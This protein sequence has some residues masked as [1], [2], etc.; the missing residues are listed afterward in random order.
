M[1][2]RK[3]KPHNLHAYT[4]AIYGNKRTDLYHVHCLVRREDGTEIELD[5]CLCNFISQIFRSVM[6]LKMF[7]A[8]IIER[9]NINKSIVYS[10]IWFEQ[11]ER[12]IKALNESLSLIQ[13]KREHE[14]TQDR[15]S[16]TLNSDIEPNECAKKR[17]INPSF[18]NETENQPNGVDPTG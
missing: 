15:A 17:K 5:S 6:C 10:L 16:I 13:K 11:L 1:W 2:I 3:V 14:E 9:K 8:I 7:P 18:Q 4:C 12:H